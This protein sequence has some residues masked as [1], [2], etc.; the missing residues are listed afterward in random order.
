MLDGADTLLYE[1][2]AVRVMEPQG[3]EFNQA[4]RTGYLDL[5][6][7]MGSDFPDR[8]HFDFKAVDSAKGEKAPP[9]GVESR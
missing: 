7:S 2:P 5:G 9:D 4:L 1:V 8:I 3:P 6:Q